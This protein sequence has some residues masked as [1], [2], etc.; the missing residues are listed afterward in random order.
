MEIKI[1]TENCDCFVYLSK[2]KDGEV[3][4][5][6]IDPPYN[7]GVDKWDKWKKKEDYFLFMEQVFKECFRVLKDNGTLLWFHSDRKQF[8]ELINRCKKTGLEH[9]SEVII[10][11]EN[12]RVQSWK[13]LKETNALKH[14]FNVCEY[15]FHFVKMKDDRTGLNY[16]TNNKETFK[17]HRE[18]TRQLIKITN[19]TATQ[20]KK[21]FGN[22]AIDHF[23]RWD[24]IQFSFP[25]EENYEKLLNLYNL[26]YGDELETLKIIKYKELKETYMKKRKTYEQEI[27]EQEKKRYTFNTGCL[28]EY[29]NIYIIKNN[30][31]NGNQD[32]KTHKHATPKDLEL[33]KNLIKVHSNEGDLVVDCFLGTG[34]TL[35]A[36]KELKRNFKGCE[37]NKDYYKHIIQTT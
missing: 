34:T 14:W 3:D 28:E 21:E 6:L 23:L 25:T 11:K 16:I 35:K 26:K 32:K 36:C 8:I 22:G 7:I 20:I 37:I 30:M 31:S 24:T 12:F 4:L 19:K 13:N 15:C 5:I 1:E 10:I 33:I 17:E 18:Y 27:K 2:L 29:R 9:L